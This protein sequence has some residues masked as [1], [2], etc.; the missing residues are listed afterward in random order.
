[1][2]TFLG[3]EPTIELVPD[4]VASVPITYQATAPI[5]ARVNE[6]AFLLTPPPTPNTPWTPS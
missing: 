3:G 5:I 6:N 2:T 1:M 4:G